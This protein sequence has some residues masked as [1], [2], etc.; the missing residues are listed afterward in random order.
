MDKEKLIRYRDSSYFLC[1]DGDVYLEINSTLRK[2]KKNLNCGYLRCY[3]VLPIV[4]GTHKSISRMTG[5]VFLGAT[6]KDEVDHIDQDKTNN[7]LSN[8]RLCSR[9]E[10]NSN[11]SKQ[12][13][14][15]TG[16]KGVVKRKDGWY[17]AR[18]SKD[19]QRYCLGLFK[20][21]EEASIA[22]NKKAIELHGSFASLN[23]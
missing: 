7:A 16:F 19:G 18:I 15:T 22:Y 12:K 6:A 21:A 13:N 17:R 2:V 5:E 8:L 23:K 4:G 14:N 20:T 1:E 3:L 10:N 11:K 9:S